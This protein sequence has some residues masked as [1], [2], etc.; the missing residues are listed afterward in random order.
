[1]GTTYGD[2]PPRRTDLV[3]AG[4][5]LGVSFGVVALLGACI[6]AS[7]AVSTKAGVVV[8]GLSATLVGSGALAGAAASGT[9]I[10]VV[11]GVLMAS[12]GAVIIEIGIGGA[13]LV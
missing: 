6:L 2:T 10:G 8:V 9:A 7:F 11:L 5:I 3:V 4:V 12:V 1:M 13:I